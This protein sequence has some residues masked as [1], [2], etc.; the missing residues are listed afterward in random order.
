MPADSRDMVLVPEVQYEVWQDDMPVASAD[1]LS[2]AQHYMAMYGQDGPVKAKTA[3]TYRVDGFTSSAP[4]SPIAA[5]E[6]PHEM[7]EAFLAEAIATSPKP[8]QEL[9]RFL[10]DLLGED[11]WKTADRY[12]IALAT[13]RADA[14]RAL[15]EIADRPLIQEPKQGDYGKDR[16]R[17]PS[18]RHAWH[19]DEQPHHALSCERMLA[20]KV[21]SA[22]PARGEGDACPVC[23]CE[24]RTGA[25]YLQCECPAPSTTSTAEQPPHGYLV[26]DFADGWFWTRDASLA[27][28]DGA[29]VWSLQHGR[30]E[31]EAKPPAPSPATP[32]VKGEVTDEWAER[33]C[34]AVN[35]SPDGQECKT[36]EGQLRCVSFRD[37][38]KGYILAAIATDPC[39]PATPAGEEMRRD[40]ERYRFL[41]SRDCG[42]L[43]GPTPPGPFI[44]L[45]PENMILTEEDA[46]RHIDQAILAALQ[47]Q[48]EG[49][50]GERG[51]R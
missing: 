15:T 48:A 18:C 39:T 20:T 44:G 14:W 10:S 41:R 34:E 24:E 51:E 13:I 26:K 7:F 6:D 50:E 47:P 45:V 28:A 21:L 17:C 46:D 38:A 3:F 16:E 22:S 9:G 1:R 23:G 37:L 35:W 43:D 33:F 5:G 19:V 2:D 42:P 29:A 40:A 4:P 12:L 36:V 32:A 49:G 30:Y 27:C 11:D 8:L 25:G 31:T